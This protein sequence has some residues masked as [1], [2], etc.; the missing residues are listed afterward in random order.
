[1]QRDSWSALKK[2]P[3]HVARASNWPFLTGQTL[4]ASAIVE[5]VLQN[6]SQAASKP[7]KITKKND[8]K[9][10]K[11]KVKLENQL[12]THYFSETHLRSTDRYIYTHIFIYI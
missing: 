4:V 10:K 2:V 11:K 5:S 12:L 8:G 1:M 9:P 3:Q 6:I 7:I